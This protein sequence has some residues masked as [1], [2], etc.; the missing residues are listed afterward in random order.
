ME[1]NAQVKWVGLPGAPSLEH[2]ELRKAFVLVRS[3][4]DW[5]SVGDGDPRPRCWACILLRLGEK[6]V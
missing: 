1:P 2:P 6:E 3:S 4:L 5:M